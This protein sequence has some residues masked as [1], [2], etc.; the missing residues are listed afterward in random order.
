MI[1]DPRPDETPAPD[2]PPGLGEAPPGD[3]PSPAAI[4]ATEQP[5]QIT[6]GLVE[7]ERIP[8]GMV[9]MGCYR[10]GR[11]VARSVLPP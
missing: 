11:L 10:N 7:D 2:E 6:V 9:C 4:A 5:V 3:S 8:D 1:D